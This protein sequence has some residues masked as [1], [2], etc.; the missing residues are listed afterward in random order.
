AA[1]FAPAAAHLP[2]AASPTSCG[3]RHAA[4]SPVPTTPSILLPI[5]SDSATPATRP[6]KSLLSSRR[7]F[8]VLLLAAFAFIA[9]HLLSTP[10]SDEVVEAAETVEGAEHAE[11]V[12]VIEAAESTE[13]SVPWLMPGLAAYG[14]DSIALI[15]N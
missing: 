4:P 9:G 1:H 7:P 5:A 2:A 15:A 13:Q 10:P 3:T 14:I 11:T 12:K 6:A 8:A